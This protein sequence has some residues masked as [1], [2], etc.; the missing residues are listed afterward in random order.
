MGKNWDL[1]DFKWDG[2]STGTSW[3]DLEIFLKYDHLHIL[4]RMI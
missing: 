2:L 1:K 3:T 4:Q